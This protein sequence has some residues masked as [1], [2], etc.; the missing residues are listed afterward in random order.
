MQ[1]EGPH[2][3]KVG[4]RESPAVAGAK[5]VGQPLPQ[6]FPVGAAAS[7]LLLELNDL[8]AYLPISRGQDGVD[9]LGG[10]LA[11]SLEQPGNPSR[12]AL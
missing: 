5:I 11:R 7:P 12:T 3:R 9:R 4:L 2:Q 8:P 1:V 6:A 10:R